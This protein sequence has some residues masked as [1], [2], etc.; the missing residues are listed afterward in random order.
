MSNQNQYFIPKENTNKVEEVRELE[1]KKSQLS[2]EA[3]KKVIDKSGSNYQ[4]PLIDSEIKGYGPC[5]WNNPNCSCQY[6][7]R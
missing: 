7:E 5:N 6:G 1:T 2:P 3:R 4:S